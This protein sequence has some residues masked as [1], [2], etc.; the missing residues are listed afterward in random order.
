MAKKYP[1]AK[2]LP[3]GA[4]EAHQS[5]MSSH[6]IICLHTMVGTLLGTDA[7]FKQDGYGGTESHFGV[8]ANADEGIHQ[9][10]DLDRRADA[11]LD[12]NWHVISVETAD[13]GGPFPDWTGSNVPAWNDWQIEAI[14][15]LVA[16]L[17]KR[18]DI[19]ARLIPD[20]LPNRR[21]IAY[22]R[23]G[24]KGNWPDESGWKRGEI[25]SEGEGKPCP[26]DRRIKQIT[27]AIIPRVNE[28]L[29]GDDMSAADV[30]EIVRDI[31]EHTT[32]QVDRAVKAVNARAKATREA[33]AKL[34]AEIDSIP[35]GA[36]VADVKQVVKDQIS[37]IEATIVLEIPDTE[38][39]P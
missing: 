37:N 11:N 30:R 2:W 17:C 5:A 39:T 25:W 20:T 33:L 31:N 1:A 22:H 4:D 26:G 23:Q 19:P 29:N 36:S 10:T 38:E 12:G 28:I 21:G 3:L 9:Y 13:K 24:I 18:Y 6:D 7:Y 8:G 34:R 15:Q 32:Q 14:A 35:E 16:W 27:K